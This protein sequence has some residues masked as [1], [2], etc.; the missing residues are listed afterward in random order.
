MLTNGISSGTVSPANSLLSTETV[1]RMLEDV[2]EEAMVLEVACMRV[3]RPYIIRV[4]QM[5]D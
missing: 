4:S 1:V 5:F 3:C 2:L